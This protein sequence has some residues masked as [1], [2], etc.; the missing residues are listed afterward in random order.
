MEKYLG[1]K[2]Q[3][4]ENNYKIS[5]KDVL[6]FLDLDKKLGTLLAPESNEGN[7]SIR[8]K[9]GFL[10]KKSGA[11]MTVLNS[12]DVVFVRSIVDG[13]IYCLGGTPSSE[14]RMHHLI[15]E[16]HK[17]INMILHFHSNDLLGILNVP[18]TGPFPYGSCELASAINI[19][20]MRQEIVEII[21]HGFVIVATDG[22]SLINV[23]SRI[24][25]KSGMNL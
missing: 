7:M 13:C 2:F 11:R 22:N 24:L 12:D 17:D 15:Y 3:I 10:I 23:L 20:L 19:C 9:N 25:T 14:T 21:D 6:Q 8:I 18:R 5:K 16:S 1:V 4:I